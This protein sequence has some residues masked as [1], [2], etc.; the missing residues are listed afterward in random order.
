MQRFDSRARASV[1]A[2]AAPGTAAAITA[3]PGGGSVAASPL[4]ATAA[5]LLGLN[6][7]LL[8]VERLLGLAMCDVGKK[9]TEARAHRAVPMQ[10]VARQKDVM[11][12]LHGFIERREDLVSRLEH[13]RQDKP[14]YGPLVV[15]LRDAAQ[16]HVRIAVMLVHGKK[17]LAA[18]LRD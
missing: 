8:H 2:R 9:A 13:Q 7:N 15:A 11:A 6:N 1:V 3:A 18:N 14:Q 5:R 12:S 10:N 16:N 17:K 4:A